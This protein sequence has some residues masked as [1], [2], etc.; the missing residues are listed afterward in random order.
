MSSSQT[1]K[2]NPNAHLAPNDRYHTA[3]TERR[4]DAASHHGGVKMEK[5]VSATGSITGIE[6]VDWYDCYKAYKAEKIRAEASTKASSEDATAGSPIVP[7]AGDSQSKHDP[8]PSSTLMVGES[9]A[10]IPVTSRDESTPSLQPSQSGSLAFRRRSL[11]IR[12]TISA[13]DHKM[14]SPNPKRSS[15][16]ERPRQ[17][18]GGST[19]S[20]I[21]GDSQFSALKRKK[22]LNLVNKMEGWWN[23]VKSNFNPDPPESPAHLSS[24][25]PHPRT[26]SAPQ[27]RRGS[28]RSSRTLIDDSL[29]VP[30]SGR[31][32]STASSSRSLRRAPVSQ[33][34]FHGGETAT[35][36]A[37][38][39]FSA[40]KPTASLPPP[41]L[42]HMEPLSLPASD[43]A[44]RRGLESRRNQPSLRLVLE[45]AA[46]GIHSMEPASLP[47]A[48]G[49][50]PQDIRPESAFSSFPPS[51]SRPSSYGS[52]PGFS[53][54][55]P[56][57]AALASNPSSHPD[58]DNKPVAP[59]AEVTVASVRQHVKQRL[60]A[61]K[62]QC[63]DTLR[64][65]MATISAFE[66]ERLATEVIEDQRRDYFD[67]FS[68][69]PIMDP[70]DSED[71]NI[72]PIGSCRSDQIESANNSLIK[73]T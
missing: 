42:A 17:S 46:L 70:A 29:A 8:L 35:S 47:R 58:K 54:R 14:S 72:P 39:P 61:A 68:D 5:Q 62:V 49:T 30:E 3:K 4:A 15:V 66:E 1:G 28:R 2:L 63:D 10:P 44:V 34:D 73:G 21:A 37:T 71:D 6:W 32:I 26:P 55:D 11:S 22:N 38:V 53:K 20:S 65:I 13:I 48:I 24:T 19:K 36:S 41:P 31:Q 40:L 45:P 25:G 7:T 9:T 67:T 50:V 52:V 64:R 23:A 43:K 59:G 60:N 16:L 18:S 56:T 57:P 12:S 33:I 27:S 69:S 51:D